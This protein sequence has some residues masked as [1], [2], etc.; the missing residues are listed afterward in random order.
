MIS[1]TTIE[2]EKPQVTEIALNS[3]SRDQIVF[4]FENA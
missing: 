4:S 3:N 2:L 1:D